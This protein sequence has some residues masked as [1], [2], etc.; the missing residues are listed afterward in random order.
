MDLRAFFRIGRARYIRRGVSR[1][2]I[3]LWVVYGLWVAWVSYNAQGHITKE[4][5]VWSLAL[6]IVPPL[7]VYLVVKI[8]EWVVAGFRAPRHPVQQQPTPSARAGGREVPGIWS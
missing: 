2:L 6:I 1:L 8:V 4:W 3:V 5:I 7:V